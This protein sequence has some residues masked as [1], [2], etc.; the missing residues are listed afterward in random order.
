M[1]VYLN[2]AS[3]SVGVGFGILTA[4]YFYRP[5]AAVTV[6]ALYT[7]LYYFIYLKDLKL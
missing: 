5:K 2:A 7:C 6:A 1:K 4:R 3:T